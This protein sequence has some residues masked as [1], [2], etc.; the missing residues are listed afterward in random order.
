M[1]WKTSEPAALYA[2]CQAVLVSWGEEENTGAARSREW[3]KMMHSLYGNIFDA[4]Y[5]NYGGPGYAGGE[6]VGEGDMVH[7]EVE[8]VDNLDAIFK[9]HDIDY[10]SMNRESA[11]D[12]LLSRLAEHKP[13]SWSEFIA[14]KAAQVAFNEP[15]RSAAY[16]LYPM[17]SPQKR[18]ADQIESDYSAVIAAKRN[19]AM[20]SLNGNTE[21][22]AVRMELPPAAEMQAPKTDAQDGKVEA[23]DGAS[24]EESGKKLVAKVQSL[25]K[26][27]YLNPATDYLPTIDLEGSPSDIID[28]LLDHGH[29][30]VIN[31]KQLNLQT[32]W[33][34]QEA[35]SGTLTRGKNLRFQSGYGS[36]CKQGPVGHGL[37]EVVDFHWYTNDLLGNYAYVGGAVSNVVDTVCFGALEPSGTSTSVVVSKDFSSKVAT[38]LMTMNARDVRAWEAVA[39]SNVIGFDAMA[40][41]YRMLSIFGPESAATVPLA[42]ESVVLKAMFYSML[43]TSAADQLAVTPDTFYTNF[44][45]RILMPAPNAPAWWPFSHAQTI[46]A[47]CPALNVMMCTVKQYCDWK[48]RNVQP[49]GTVVQWDPADTSIAIVPWQPSFGLS[50]GEFLLWVLSHLEYPMACVAEDFTNMV[51]SSRGANGV[52]GN[53]HSEAPNQF[54]RRMSNTMSLRIKGPTDKILVVVPDTLDGLRFYTSVGP[55]TV[56]PA[57]GPNGLYGGNPIA[58]QTVFQAALPT[59]DRFGEG[60]LRFLARY[61]PADV[62][63]QALSVTAATCYQG[64]PPWIQGGGLAANPNVVGFAF[65]NDDNAYGG[66]LERLGPQVRNQTFRQYRLAPGFEQRW[67]SAQVIAGLAQWT[68]PHIIPD[69][70]LALFFGSYIQVSGPLWQIPDIS[71]TVRRRGISFT[72]A[73]DQIVNAVGLSFNAMNTPA[74]YVGTNAYSA[75]TDQVTQIRELFYSSFKW[76][77]A[78]RER[79]L[80]DNGLII[81]DQALALVSRIPLQ[82]YTRCKLDF[83]AIELDRLKTELSSASWP[84]VKQSSNVTEVASLLNWSGYTQQYYCEAS[85][86]AQFRISLPMTPLW[87]TDMMDWQLT[88]QVAIPNPPSHSAAH[89]DLDLT[90]VIVS[91]IIPFF[92]FMSVGLAPV[93]RESLLFTGF[94]AVPNANNIPTVNTIINTGA[95]LYA[96]SPAIQQIGVTFA[97]NRSISLKHQKN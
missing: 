27:A 65:A 94:N 10:M 13:M 79:S 52:R 49:V 22:A 87:A 77:G 93:G 85:G 7:W 89:V 90:R 6:T 24:K 48:N 1:M 60:L 37:S 58:V 92:G 71:E 42:M 2:E 34:A 57:I 67:G 39:A 62:F 17:P 29:S 33:N 80:N 15:F 91:H 86:V 72:L 73:V 31:R 45:A 25:G 36:E 23:Q 51:V 70:E 69:T 18:S 75:I 5:G 35:W 55:T 3:N 74:L 97:M 41:Q 59:I 82:F 11:D 43:R 12:L 32:T 38:N 19:K 8:P 4:W 50:D 46:N 68:I 63:D 61:V 64:L 88:A 56:A 54:M 84:A 40:L 95:V 81:T 14:A 53:T 96:D 16:Y 28:A 47:N 20:H 76:L 9:A 78:A 44:N 21:S 26:I 66:A 83:L 30:Y